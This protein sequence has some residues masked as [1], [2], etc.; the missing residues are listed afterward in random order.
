MS[1]GPASNVGLKTGVK[2][3]YGPKILN[4]PPSHATLP[5]EY[6][7]PIVSRGFILFKLGLKLEIYSNFGLKKE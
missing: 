1:N 6:W 2:R 4:G 5:F 7:T 3:V